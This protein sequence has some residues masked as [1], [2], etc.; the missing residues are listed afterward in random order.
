ML[1]N[2]N[3]TTARIHNIQFFTRPQHNFH[4]THLDFI[5]VFNLLEREREREWEEPLY[6]SVTTYVIHPI[7]RFKGHTHSLCIIMCLQF[8]FQSAPNQD[9]M[10]FKT[11]NVLEKTQIY[12][13]K[14][15]VA[16]IFDTGC[17]CN[18]ILD[19]YV[20]SKVNHGI[21]FKIHNCSSLQRFYA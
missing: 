12:H 21:T 15:S 6:I 19:V 17:L 20:Q 13:A 11:L 1:G 7:T 2:N 9:K 10:L 8:I 5:I 16:Y 3:F 14:I 18:S 4:R